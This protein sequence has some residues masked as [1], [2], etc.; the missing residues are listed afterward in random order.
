GNAAR[1]R[2]KG[3][4]IG[5][6]VPGG[7]REGGV[8]QWA[9][10]LGWRNLALAEEIARKFPYPVFVENDV[11]LLALGEYWYGI[12]QGTRSL[13]CLA[14][15]TGLGAGIV[16]DGQVYTGAHAAAG[17]VCN[18]V[19][20]ISYLGRTYPGF[21]WLEGFVSGPALARRYASLLEEMGKGPH[22]EVLPNVDAEVVFA[23]AR[24][25]EPIACRV[26]EEFTRY[27]ALALVSIVAVLDPEMIVLGGGVSESADVFRDRLVE[28]CSPVLQVMPRVEVSRL[29]VDAGVMGAVAL[30][31]HNTKENPWR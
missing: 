22:S 30:A 29:G 5:V 7:V 1:V 4:G 25:G 13:V 18:L 3:R 11:N 24:E 27:L 21:G 23:R 9:P 31:L 8:V 16:L 20:D 10:A 12:G 17:E 14:V 15:G 19:A 28:L 2:E 6:G 26:V